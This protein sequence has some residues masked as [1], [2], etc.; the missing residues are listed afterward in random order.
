MRLTE[1][2]HPVIDYQVNLPRVVLVP[3]SRMPEVRINF[4]SRRTGKQAEPYAVRLEAGCA[5]KPDYKQRQ[6]QVYEFPLHSIFVSVS[7]RMQK[8]KE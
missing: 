8:Y 7:I 6:E 4:A 2:E 3:D 1:I 5:G